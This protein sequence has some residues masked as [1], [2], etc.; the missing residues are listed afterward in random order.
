[1]AKRIGPKMRDVESLTS[2]YPG[3]HVAWYAERVG[4]HGS[5]AFGYRT[6]YRAVSAGLVKLV[7]GERRG[8][9]KVVPV[10]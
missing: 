8:W 7:R 6:V 9:S 2:Q 10:K 3:R 5:L 4:P 1:M